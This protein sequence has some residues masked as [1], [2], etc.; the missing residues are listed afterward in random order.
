MADFYVV[1]SRLKSHVSGCPRVIFSG[2]KNVDLRVSSDLQKICLAQPSS[3]PLQRAV[4]F[5]AY[6]WLLHHQLDFAFAHALASQGVE[7]IVVLC[8][9]VQRGVHNPRGC[10]VLYAAAHPEA[11]CT[12]CFQ[13]F[14]QVFQG[15]H[16]LP[17]ESGAGADQ[18]THQFLPDLSEKTLADAVATSVAGIPFFSMAYSTLC[19]RYRVASVDQLDDWPVLLR[20]E[21]Q[22][23]AKVWVGLD[24]HRVFLQDRS[25]RTAAFVFNARF[26]PYRVAYEFFRSLGI[27]VYVHERGGSDDNYSIVLNRRVTEPLYLCNSAYIRALAALSC[28]HKNICAQAA[29][30]KLELKIKGQNTGWFSFVSDALSYVPSSDQSAAGD[31]WVSMFTSSPD[32]N[33]K[34]PS[35]DSVLHRQLE[36]LAGVSEVLQ[37][38]GYQVCIRHHPHTSSEKNAGGRGAENYNVE[39]VARSSSFNRVIL[40]REPQNSLGLAT[41]SSACIALTSSIC[42]EIAQRKRKCLVDA[43]SLFAP[44]FPSRMV[45]ALNLKTGFYDPGSLEHALAAPPMNDQE[46]EHFLL[47]VYQIYFLN[48][49]T[50][51]SFGYI[52]NIKLRHPL[53]EVLRLIPS[54]SL[55]HELA[56]LIRE[57]RLV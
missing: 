7:I 5:I 23:A 54:D 50:F 46:Y 14:P 19:T 52:E 47:G 1:R 13:G 2:T 27:D 10:E 51:S 17:L 28:R 6:P 35:L 31:R 30:E 34:L 25:S 11:L 21:A 8:N 12:G 40:G 53:G 33:D 57:R 43:G 42:L 32:E 49:Y 20:E 9:R 24:Q 45:L 29:S 16:Q 15:F 36:I 56:A 44:L 38:L 41:A 3:E 4:F 22:V 39:A 48:K 26:T 55:L 18:I 37:S